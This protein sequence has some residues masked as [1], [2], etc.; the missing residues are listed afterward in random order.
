MIVFFVFH[1]MTRGKEKSAELRWMSA[2]LSPAYQCQEKTAG[3]MIIG[4]LYMHF[5]CS[6]QRGKYE[7]SWNLAVWAAI[8]HSVWLVMTFAFY[9]HIE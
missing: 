1:I 2:E 4:L 9:F 6:L 8:V 7:N 5:R 3:K